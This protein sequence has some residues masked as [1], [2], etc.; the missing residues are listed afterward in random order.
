MLKIIIINYIYIFIIYYFFFTCTGQEE[1]DRLRPL[2]YPGTDVFLLCYSVVDTHSYQNVRFRWIPE[3]THQCP[4]A[5]YFLVGLKI[6]LR[7]DPATV[8]QMEAAGQ[9]P[10]TREDG[11]K[12][13]GELGAMGYFECSALLQQNINETFEGVIRML[14]GGATGA[15]TAAAA[16]SADTGAAGAGAG[17]AAGAAAN[18]GSGSGAGGDAKSRK[19]KP[20][21]M[22]L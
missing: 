10:Y 21:C 16:G 19:R 8:K 5:K 1:Y 7:T 6:D 14:K 11:E 18:G 20:N 9:R 12:L 13:A 22:I 3:V 4:T 17:G 15:N 2:S